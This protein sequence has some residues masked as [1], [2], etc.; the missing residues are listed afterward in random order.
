MMCSRYEAERDLGGLPL[1]GERMSR[2]EDFDDFTLSPDDLDS[3]Q[4]DNSEASYDDL[5][6]D[7]EPQ[8]APQPVAEVPARPAKPKTRAARPAKPKAKPKAK[9]KAKT[10]KPKAAKPKAKKAAKSSRKPAAR[11]VAAKK[12]T[13]IKK[14]AKKRA[15]A[16]PKK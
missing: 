13:A 6:A 12:K 15:K 14:T 9:A 5:V 10:A 1:E 16:K 7:E 8:A 4:V 2:E 11:K 3:G